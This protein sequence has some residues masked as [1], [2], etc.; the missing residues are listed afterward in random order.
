MAE[1]GGGGMGSGRTPAVFVSYASQDAAVAS[2]LVEALER[3]SFACWIAPRDVKPGAQYADAIV[4]A[5]SGAKAFV[6][7]LS[8]SAI[9][10]SHVSKEIERATSK[11]RPIIALRIDAA[12]LTPALE[13]FLGESQWVE[14]QAGD[15]NAAHIKLIDAI[16]DLVP[17]APAINSPAISGVP[18]AKVP[19][20][21]PALWRNPFALAAGVAAIVAMAGLLTDRLWTSKRVSP[22]KP[23]AAVASA[24]LTPP[25]HSIAVLPFVN[26]SGDKEQNYFSDGLTEELLNSLARINELQVAARTSS[27]SFQGQHPD[28]ATVARKLNVG[29]VLE[30]SVRRSANTVRVTAQLINGVTGFHIWSQTYDRKLGDVLMLQTEIATA[31][32]SALKV[33]LL[34]DE[35]AKI[36]VGGTRN[37]AA[38]DAYLRAT[39]AYFSVHTV[40][41]QEAVIDDYTETIRLDPDYALAYAG[42]SF[43]LMNFGWKHDA[44]RTAKRFSSLDKAQADARKAIALA[45]GLAEGHLALASYCAGSLDFTRA[46]DEFERALALGPGN[47]RVLRDYGVFAVAMGRTDFGLTS[48]RRAVVLD[49]LNVNAYGFLGDALLNLRR[50]EEFIAV[51]QNAKA[52]DPRSFEGSI[53]IGHYLLGD[54]QAARTQCEANGEKN[55][56]AQFCLALSYDKLGRHPE[57]EAMLQKMRAR[58][59]DSGAMHYSAIYAQWGDTIKAL[60]WLDTSVRLRDPTLVW[61]KLDPFFDPLRKEPR[62]QA[63]EQTVKFP[64]Q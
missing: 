39:K 1:G 24:T 20:A 18:P 3:H 11:R 57:A 45:P 58:V 63:I 6:V 60:E 10:S 34:G 40:Q 37:P 36:E 21:G 44:P 31:V 29:A 41:D 30:G 17:D 62:F 16:G 23:V 51:I 43:V 32:A 53:G 19:A 52:L 54:F 42:R 33:T 59:G 7:V 26:M 49:P 15:I 27:F 47:A 35:A 46:T 12:P 9:A 14:A 64:S 8:E 22:E 5:I 2:A 25:P 50:Y 4:R 61:L 55:E 13:Y 48:L 28:I 56:D 38:F